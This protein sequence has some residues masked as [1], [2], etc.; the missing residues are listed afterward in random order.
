VVDGSS[1]MSFMANTIGTDSKSGERANASYGN[2]R[3]SQTPT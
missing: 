3:S 2:F 1:I